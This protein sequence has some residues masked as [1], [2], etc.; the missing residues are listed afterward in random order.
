MFKEK[1]KKWAELLLDTGKRNSLVSFKDTK[2]ST[3][4]IVYPDVDT[5]FSKIDSIPSFEVYDAKITSAEEEEIAL[6]NPNYVPKSKLD[7]GTYISTFSPKLK[8]ASQI[9]AFNPNVNSKI[10]L[11]NISKKARSAIEEAGVN[12]A[13]AAFGF[14][15]WSER[16]DSRECHKAPILLAPIYIT[17][18]SSIDPYQIKVMGDEVIVN[19]TFSFKLFSEFGIK[20]PEYEGDESLDS[21]ISKISDTIDRLGWEIIK[22]CKIGIFSFQKI[23]MYHDLN[24]NMDKIL[25]N[26]NVIRL[27]RQLEGIE[28]PVEFT[29]FDLSNELIQLHSVVDADSSQ[30]DAIELAKSGQSFVLQGPPGTGKSQ[31]ITNIVAELLN[32]GKRVLFVSEKLAA[33]NVVYDKLKN[34]GLSD[35]CLELHSNK[36]SKKEVIAELS[37]VLRLPQKAVSKKAEYEIHEKEAHQLALDSY[38]EELHKVNEVVGKSLF[39]LYGLYYTIDDSVPDDCLIP[40]VQ[41]TDYETVEYRLSLIRQFMSLVPDLGLDYRLNP[42]YGFSSDDTSYADA[43]KVKSILN[44]AISTILELDSL[45]G[46]LFAKYGI[47][48][49]TISELRP[50][51]KLFSFV[52]ESNIVTPALCNK[53]LLNNVYDKITSLKSLASKIIR[54]KRYLSEY[55]KD[56]FFDESGIRYQEELQRYTNF[57]VRPFSRSYRSLRDRICYHY[58]HG[59]RLSYGNLNYYV[60]M[61]VRYQ[62]D[63]ERFNTISE[64]IKGFLGPEFVGVESSFDKILESLDNLK[65]LLDSVKEPYTID[66]SSSD[67]ITEY[68]NISNSIINKLTALKPVLFNRFNPDALDVEGS[69]IEDVLNKLSACYSSWNILNSWYKFLDLSK[70]FKK[71]FID[72]YIIYS[73]NVGLNVDELDKVYEKSYIKQWIDLITFDSPVISTFTRAKQDETV[74][75]FCEKDLLQFEISKAQ[76]SST[77]SEKRPSLDVIIS[78]SPVALL[79]REAE[80]KRKQKSILALLS[81]IGDFVQLLKPCFLMSPI[82]VSTFLATTN[83]EFDAIIFDEAS[84]IFPQDAIGSIYRGKQLIVVGDSRQMP[85]SNFFNTSIE[86]SDEDT[87]DVTD[88]E[89]ILDVCSCILPQLRL[90][91]HYR[92]RYEQLI[93]FS[94]KCFYDNSLVTFPSP[95]IDRQWIGVDYHYVDG[96]FDRT[97]KTNYIEAERVVDLIYENIEKFP[98]RSLGVVAFSISQQDLID[99]LLYARRSRFPDKEFFFRSDR[100]EPFFIK[101][102]ETV[103]GDERDTIIFST[104]YAKDATGKFSHNFGPL[105][106]AG[107]ERRLNVAVTR[108]KVNVQLVTSIHAGDI[109]LERAKSTGAR[110]FKEYLD[111]AETGILKSPE[112]VVESEFF[113]DPLLFEK[114]ICQFLDEKSIG[115]DVQLGASS[116]RIDIAVKHPQLNSYILAIECDGDSYRSSKN[117]RDRDRLRKE[118]LERMGWRHYRIWSTQWIKNKESEKERLF[119][120]IRSAI[121]SSLPLEDDYTPEAVADDFTEELEGKS[122]SFPEYEIVDIDYLSSFYPNKLELIV[123]VLEKEAPLAEKWLLKRMLNV[124]GK[125]SANPSA[126]AAL[127]SVLSGC[128]RYNISR[129]DGFLYY[130]S[131]EL[132]F[133]AS[134]ER[135]R[136]I[137]YISLDELALG[138][139]KI[140]EH[141]ATTSKDGLF[142]TVA[143]LL[144]MARLTPAIE[145]RLELALNRIDSSLIKIDGDIISI[146]D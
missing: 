89:S 26:Q 98:E 52:S 101:N 76:I 97:T 91:W 116:L 111:Y 47:E 22:E 119:E 11:K 122:L 117:A 130:D 107:G 61:L 105:N 44:D 86:E 15:K 54:D 46:D 31:T 73:I 109:S 127:E 69:D 78:G 65:A 128:E 124:L 17:R 33:L 70:E 6:I 7:R 96:I 84:Q 66:T 75:L 121:S 45:R 113:D 1:L 38:V 94:N 85:P 106:R 16:E 88:F 8:K 102:L 74:S 13:Y 110:L 41:S 71:H 63:L 139:L 144:G 81:E 90:R 72:R 132:Q 59:H 40:N 56:S 136:E 87:D 67:D 114:D 55:F 146:K 14:I 92:S 123:K 133:R 10:A 108:A 134:R 143:S 80:K 135:L 58:K 145:E 9:L 141:T 126:V 24:G 5:F 99:R 49:R 62:E 77:L 20:L 18:D 140:I 68:C 51:C 42:W 34:A 104:A 60:N 36:S 21:Y 48:I 93:A 39:Q 35:Y 57:L 43:L 28:E 120:A 103:Q 2:S 4:E 138:L 129:Y 137:K 30:I 12:V 79:L 50:L 3:V 115:Y 29:P 64:E 142:H 19:P 131:M 82:S 83:I 95:A 32:D 37:R 27:M 25:E 112:E 118:V 53:S 125:K 23:N 100:P